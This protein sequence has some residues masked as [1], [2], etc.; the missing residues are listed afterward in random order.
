MSTFKYGGRII[1][2]RKLSSGGRYLT[3]KTKVRPQSISCAVCCDKHDM[4]PKMDVILKF[5]T[6]CYLQVMWLVRKLS[7]YCRNKLKASSEVSF[8]YQ[9]ENAT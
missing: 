7:Q 4:L 9:R 5:A 1:I 6:S 8:C 2:R 3:R